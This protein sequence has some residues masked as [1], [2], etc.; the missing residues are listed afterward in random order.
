MEL[1]DKKKMAHRILEAY[2]RPYLE[3]LEF[4]D[5]YPDMQETPAQFQ[6]RCAQIALRCFWA[7]KNAEKELDVMMGPLLPASE[8]RELHGVK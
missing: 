7:E 1:N 3:M 6:E 4:I 2:E 8:R 5:K